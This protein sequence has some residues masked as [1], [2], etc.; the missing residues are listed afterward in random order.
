MFPEKEST[1]HSR[2]C[3]RMLA[4]ELDAPSSCSQ[5]SF[6]W[7]LTVDSVEHAN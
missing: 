3:S 6:F 1:R 4:R 7:H 5:V 2:T